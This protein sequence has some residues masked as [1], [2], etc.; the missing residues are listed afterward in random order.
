MRILFPTRVLRLLSS[1]WCLLFLGACS[2]SASRQPAALD[3]LGTLGAVPVAKLKPL[4][5]MTLTDSSTV[6]KFDSLLQ[7]KGQKIKDGYYLLIQV[8]G[9]SHC[10]DTAVSFSKHNLNSDRITFILT[11]ELGGV[12]IFNDHYTED[13]LKTVN[14]VLD[15]ESSFIRE[16]FCHGL[17]TV[18]TVS[19]GRLVTKT[20][21]FSDDIAGNLAWLQK[22]LR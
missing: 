10:V 17:M 16:G 4:K 2:Q 12:K 6:Y 9:C 19:N 22:E 15:G 14:M 20:P 8:D 3:T 18:F 21:L 7:D 13:E 1:L 5:L 11:S